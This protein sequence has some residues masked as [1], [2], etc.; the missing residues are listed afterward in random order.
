M[1]SLDEYLAGEFAELDRDRNEIDRV[2]DKTLN[3]LNALF[4]VNRGW[5]YEISLAK[6]K[7][8]YEWAPRVSTSTVAMISGA[9]AAAVGKGRRS[10]LSRHVDWQP[11]RTLRK[12]AYD[13]SLT[14]AEAGLK[15]VLARGIDLIDAKKTRYAFYSQTFGMDDVF[16]LT[17][18]FDLYSSLP[19]DTSGKSLAKVVEAIARTRAE[20]TNRAPVDL[21][22]KMFRIQKK[23]KID[24]VGSEHPFPLLRVLQIKSWARSVEEPTEVRE[25]LE[26]LAGL[27]FAA[28]QEEFSRRVH[29]QLSFHAIPDSRFDPAE[30]AFS[31]EGLGLASRNSLDRAVVKRT[32]AVLLEE[33]T[34]K[35]NPTLRPARPIKADPAG[36]T[37]FPLSVETFN[38][39]LRTKTLLARLFEPAF[40]RAELVSLCKRYCGWVWPRLVDGDKG[41][42]DVY[43][44]HSEHINNPRLVH[45]WQTSQ[46]LLFLLGYRTLIDSHLAAESLQAAGLS[47]R[48]SH[49]RISP[50]A[51][52]SAWD[53]VVKKYEPVTGTKPNLAVYAAIKRDFLEDHAKGRPLRFSMILYGPPGTGKTNIAKEIAN[54]LGYPLVT[55]TVSDFL[56]DGGLQIEARAKAVFKVLTAQ[57]KTV[58]IF[59]EIDQLLLDRNSDQYK[60]LDSV[61]KL[62]VPGMLTKI[63]D[64]R[65]AEQSIFVV[66]TNFE[67]RID[68]AIV[69][70][71]RIDRKYLLM[72]PDWD[73]RKEIVESILKDYSDNVR[74]INGKFIDLARENTKF[75]ASTTRMSFPEIR[76]ILYDIL[77]NVVADSDLINFAPSNKFINGLDEYRY[78]DPVADLVSYIDRK[79]QSKVAAEARAL[80]ELTKDAENRSGF[81]LGSKEYEKLVQKGSP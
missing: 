20:F 39:L 65:D 24:D 38:S 63:K 32:F 56:A 79:P 43:G 40:V 50:E 11:E 69:R 59:D 16:T 73:K 57:K 71:G 77:A 68:N 60:D 37:L 80:L 25:K 1:A 62:L 18:L 30:L 53:D 6:P 78:S 61:M 42:D 51:A 12:R 44:W 10:I 13:K 70:P 5:P 52:I 75:L 74:R 31:L 22:M 2:I 4:D 47:T 27:D 19:S 21:R 72:P 14:D 17:W 26:L 15:L 29:E 54:A 66:A 36:Q 41:R 9:L 28:W 34:Q 81:D 3:V 45:P 7:G 64:L 49:S 23:R 46:V 55:V 35:E 48:P 67:E 76:G 58:I 33:Q 8:Q